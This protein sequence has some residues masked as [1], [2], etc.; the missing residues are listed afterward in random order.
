MS[1]SSAKATAGS[2]SRESDVGSRMSDVG[3][4]KTEMSKVL[5]STKGD[6]QEESD[7]GSRPPPLKLRRAVE[8]GRRELGVALLR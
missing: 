3:S 8:V 1:P 7:V 6:R 5:T 2:G 4:R